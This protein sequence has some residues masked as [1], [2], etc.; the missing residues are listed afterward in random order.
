MPASL[1]ITTAMP[2]EDSKYVQRKHA[3]FVSRRQWV[4]WPDAPP[5]VSKMLMG[6]P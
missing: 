3:R 2:A 5:R 6:M 4:D 1:N